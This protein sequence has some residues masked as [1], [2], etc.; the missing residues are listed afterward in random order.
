MKAFWLVPA[1]VGI[2]LTVGC[3]DDALY[4]ENQSALSSSSVRLAV[5]SVS[6]DVEQAPNVA[7]NVL[8]GRSNTRWS[9]NG[10]AV[11]FYVDLGRVS[12]VDYLRIA[13]HKGDIRTN[14]FEVFTRSSSNGSWSRVGT[15]TSNGNTTG[16]QTFD[17][18]NSDGR[19]VRVLFK[20]NSI[21]LW[22]SV[23]RLEVWGSGEADGGGTGDSPGDVLGL[24]S[25]T[26][27]LNGF[28]GAPGSNARYRDDVLAATGESFGTY[29]DDNY[30]YTDGTWTYFK[31]YRGLGSSRNSG[32]PRV[33]LRELI[34]GR[35]A[36][37]DGSSGNNTMTWTVRVDRLPRDADGSGGVLCFGQIH[38]PSSTVDDV[39][40]VQ[41]IGSEDQTS[42]PVRL[43]I[44]GYI[45]E[46]VLGGSVTLDRG[47]RLDTAYTFRITYNNGVIELFSDG[48]RVFRQAMDTS[49]EGNYFKVGNYLQ[50]VQGANF[51]GSYGE[52]AVRSVSITH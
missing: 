39:I 15:K 18:R 4:H 19:Q 20:G 31:V 52:V 42:G 26:W 12:S 38:G 47:Y 41:F 46:E 22:N 3:G 50:S 35:L 14:S 2:G 11:N 32:N 27:K 34:D 29:S 5:S 40:R 33:E 17:V 23:T 7:S 21:N 9:G 36:S 6:A 49:T 28:T 8:D 48:D 37:W 13:F 24:T 1:V 25:S 30:F 16:L 43:K 45:T 44:S 10:A 51:T